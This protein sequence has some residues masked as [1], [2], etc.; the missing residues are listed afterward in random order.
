MT[1]PL[2]TCPDLD[3]SSQCQEKCTVWGQKCNDNCPDLDKVLRVKTWVDG[4]DLT[5]TFVQ[6]VI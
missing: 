4:L 2:Q 5:K 1:L 3:L 6:N